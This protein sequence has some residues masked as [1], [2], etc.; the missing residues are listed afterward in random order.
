M[1]YPP[2]RLAF[3]RRGIVGE[4][5]HDGF[6][7]GR[8][9]VERRPEILEDRVALGQQRA[10]ELEVPRHRVK[11]A[12]VA[13]DER[14]RLAVPAHFAANL[15]AAID[16]LRNRGRP[17]PERRRDPREQ[18]RARVVVAGEARV[19]RGPL[20]RIAGRRRMRAVPVHPGLEPPGAAQAR[21]VVLALEDRQDALNHAGGFV[22]TSA[23]D[24]PQPQELLI[25]ENAR[26]SLLVARPP[27]R[28]ASHG[29]EQS[30]PPPAHL[31]R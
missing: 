6:V 2:R 11:A 18:L 31:P 22:D 1:Q 21:V 8:R 17:K 27:S 16:G 20:P 14:L 19:R 24:A 29:R 7:V 3:G 25:H 5:L 12:E 13:K 26:F 4:E 15:L 10:R 9:S 23:G 30:P 28:P